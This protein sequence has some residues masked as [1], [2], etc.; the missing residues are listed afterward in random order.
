M[1]CY[2]EKVYQ[3]FL[4]G[5]LGP[6]LKRRV[7]LHAK[8]C[9]KCRDWIHRLNRENSAI[10]LLFQ[11]A[12]EAPDLSRPIMERI[13]ISLGP[14]PNPEKSR[15]R[16]MVR[17]LQFAAA[18]CLFVLFLVFLFQDR[19]PGPFNG[20]RDILIRTAMVDGH[21]VRTH[22]FASG[23]PDTIFIWLEKM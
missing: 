10:S 14:S 16:F 5:E 21:S 3:R 23:D 9:G 17:G 15:S 7:I 11:E 18:I 4:D 19:K 12:R 1:K 8:T 6:L 22:L 20:N 2:S 13:R